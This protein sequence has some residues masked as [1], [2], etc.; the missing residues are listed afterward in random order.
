MTDTLEKLRA[1]AIGRTF[2]PLTTLGGAVEAM[3]FVQADPIRAPARAQDLIL[4]QRVTGYRPGDLERRFT[5]LGLEEDFFYAYGFM[6]RETMQLLHPRP[7]AEDPAADYRPRGLAAEVLALVT[8]R[9]ETHPRDLETVFGR[10]RAVNAWGGFSKETTQ[11]LHQL[12]YHGL[13]RVVRRQDGIRVYGTAHKPHE[14][15]PAEERRR[16]LLLLLL[17]I[18]APIS[19]PALGGLLALL[20]RG[21]PGLDDVGQTLD[22]LLAAGEVERTSLDRETYLWPAGMAMDV[23]SPSRGV[24]FLAPFDPLVWDRRRFAHLWG[25]VYRFEA[26]TPPPKRQFGY[27]ALPV[28]WRDRMLG[29]VNV[30]MI[31]G[32][33]QME[34]GWIEPP[35]RSRDFTRALDAESARL[36][37]FLKKE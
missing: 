8:E 24:R 28:L 22:R 25:W 26:Y 19:R 30:R 7:D 35:P 17:G 31:D 15:L 14:P 11:V 18:F 4:R 21:A 5:R 12:H 13:L 37:E 6:P 10:D 16:R 33:M 3:G 9:R 20:R 29:W 2:R 32:Q 1:I 36:E 34:Q 27:Y 23:P